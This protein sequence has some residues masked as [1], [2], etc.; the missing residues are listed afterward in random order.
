MSHDNLPGDGNDA[1]A[2][3]ERRVAELEAAVA[4]WAHLVGYVD[5]VLGD[6]AARGGER[7]SPTPLPLPAPGRLHWFP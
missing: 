5:P 6:I 3:L 2:R 4:R 7:P 1:V